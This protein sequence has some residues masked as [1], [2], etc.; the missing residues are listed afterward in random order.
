[1]L[2]LFAFP[3]IR[4]F[5]LLLAV[6]GPVAAQDL[7]GQWQ[8]VELNPGSAVSDHWPSQLTLQGGA[9]GYA[10]SLYQEAGAAP[11]YTVRYRMK[12]SREGEQWRLT[13]AGITSENSGGFI[14]QWCEG[15]LLLTYDPEQ[16][17]LSGRSSYPELSCHGGPVEL[18]RVRLKSAAVVPARKPS[19]LEVTG[20]NVRWFA[21]AGLTRPLASGNTYRTSLDQTTTFYIRQG[22]YPT[23]NSPAVPITVHVKPGRTAT[24]PP[25]PAAPPPEPEPRAAP[26][27]LSTVLFRMGTAELMPTS[28]GALQDLADYLKANP[29]LHVRIA[30]HADRIG[31][32]AKNQR[33]SEKRA[34]AVRQ[35]LVQ[36]AG[37]P[38]DRITIIGYGHEQLL[39]P[40][41][42]ERNRRV[43]V[44]FY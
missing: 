13:H 10:G 37:I 14:G 32:A 25:R 26:Q 7:A 31:E 18:Y 21:D 35:Y 6:S 9:P 42:D 24:T 20:R 34:H 44:S 16:E 28:N 1:M 19:T 39:Y 41:P 5:I 2:R 40:A 29:E 17:K 8:G 15:T 22:F 12:V 11:K 27:V 33:L 38:P 3:E 23:A 4:L 30:G 36:Q 43:E